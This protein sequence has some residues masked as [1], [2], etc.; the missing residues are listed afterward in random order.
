M[1]FLLKETL[2]P[3]KGPESMA[4]RLS[5]D[6]EN[7]TQP[8][9]KWDN[10]IL[11]TPQEKRKVKFP[12]NFFSKDRMTYQCP[13]MEQAQELLQ[14]QQPVTLKDPFPKGKNTSYGGFNTT[15]GTQISLSSDQSYINTIHS[16]T[17][18]QTK[19][20]N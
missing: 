2:K 17:L 13:L 9:L 10:S 14:Q 3:G 5:R 20:K 18:L 1:Q 6:K 7:E 19:A 4:T 8:T 15:W 12:C 16:H 11:L